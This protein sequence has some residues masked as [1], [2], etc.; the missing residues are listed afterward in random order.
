MS[1]SQHAFSLMG[2]ATANVGVMPWKV[3]PPQKNC[4]YTYKQPE[5][6]GMKRCVNNVYTYYNGDYCIP[7]ETYA[8]VFAAG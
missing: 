7:V 6:H 4:S 8:I 3:A 1:D 5:K 2:V